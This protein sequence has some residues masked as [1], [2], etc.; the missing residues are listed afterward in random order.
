MEKEPTGAVLSVEAKFCKSSDP[1]DCLV[2]VQVLDRA[3]MPLPVCGPD[4]SVFFPK[5]QCQ[6][7]GSLFF[8]KGQCGPDG[9]LFFPKG[10]CQPDGSPFFPKVSVSLVAPFSSQRSV[11][12]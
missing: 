5:G 7:G 10:Q 6:P 1:D 12:S 11:S 8:P 2:K 9:S 3:L 4:G